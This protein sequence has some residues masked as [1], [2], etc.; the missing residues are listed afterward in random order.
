MSGIKHFR[1]IALH[2]WR[3]TLT[4]DLFDQ[5]GVVVK[6]IDAYDDDVMEQEL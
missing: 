6:P 4:P 3:D 5:G 1:I 2:D